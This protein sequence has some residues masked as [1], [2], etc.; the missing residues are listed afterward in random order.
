MH[1][2]RWI[3]C[4]LFQRRSAIHKWQFSR[5]LSGRI[6]PG[7][8]IRVACQWCM[9]G[10]LR[11]C[12]LRLFSMLSEPINWFPSPVSGSYFRRPLPVNGS[13]N[14][15]ISVDGKGRELSPA[16]SAIICLYSFHALVLKLMCDRKCALS[17]SPVANFE[18]L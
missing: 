14:T 13:D 3:L 12:S 6:W 1:H 10:G 2:R 15:G 4:R 5:P 17:S 11:Q 18:V 9:R 16:V 8:G 7:G